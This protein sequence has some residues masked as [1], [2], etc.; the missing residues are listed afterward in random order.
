MLGDHCN[1]LLPSDMVPRGVTGHWMTPIGQ[2][3]VTITLGTV[4]YRDTLHIYLAVKGV[5]LLS[6][7]IKTP[8]TVPFAYR[9]K[10]KAEL[11]ILETQGIIAPIIYPTEWCAPIVA[12]PKKDSDNIQMCVDLSHLNK[13]VKRECYQ[14]PTPSQA[15]ADIATENTTINL[16]AMKGY[17][18]CPLDEA[19]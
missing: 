5:L 14:S 8:R 1:N 16:D 3:P 7:C 9:D 13:Y 11:E 4:T 6:F 15:V 10:L 12:T 19:S 18:Q 2:L 17:H